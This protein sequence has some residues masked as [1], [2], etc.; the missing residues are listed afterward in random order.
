MDM[1]VLKQEKMWAIICRWSR[2]GSVIGEDGDGEKYEVK[3]GMVDR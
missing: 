1:L 3:Q 2:D